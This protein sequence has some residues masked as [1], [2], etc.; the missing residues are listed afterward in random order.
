MAKELAKLFITLGMDDKE[1]SKTL[2]KVQKNLSQAGKVMAGIGIGITAALGLATK[3]AEDERINIARLDA[4]LQNVGISYD[5]VS[6]SLEKNIKATQDKT[7][8]ADSE[9]RDMLSNLVFAVGDY[10]QALDLLPLSL[11]LMAA[12]E[13]D[14]K[15][16]AELLGKVAQG[17]F[18]TLS[19]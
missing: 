12:K 2:D 8:I 3:A 13:M 15:T 1:L 5:Q 6:E 16:A 17:E 19:R 9:Q 14:A 4:M 18:G 7:G 10:Q 11:D